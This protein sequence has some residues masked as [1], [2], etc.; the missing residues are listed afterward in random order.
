MG[1]PC[2]KNGSNVDPQMRK[3]DQATSNK[4]C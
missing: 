1:M 2:L 4:A 3:L